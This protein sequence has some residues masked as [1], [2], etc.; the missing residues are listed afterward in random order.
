MTT[1]YVDSPPPKYSNQIKETCK[2]LPSF[3][4]SYFKNLFQIVNW[5]PKYNLIWLSGDLTA[6]ITVGT[7]VIPQSL[8][9]GTKEFEFFHV[10]RLTLFN[11]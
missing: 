10:S 3:A 7:L 2:Q 6:A 11:S 5:F 8:A 1:I 4:R 9:Y